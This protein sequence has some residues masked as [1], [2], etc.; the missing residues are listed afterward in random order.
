MIIPSQTEI[1][2]NAIRFTRGLNTA[3]ENVC[4]SCR[5]IIREVLLEELKPVGISDQQTRQDTTTTQ[6]EEVIVP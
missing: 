5:K 6:S 3:I 2:Q 4:P 1:I